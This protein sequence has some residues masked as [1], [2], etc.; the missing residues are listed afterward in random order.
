MLTEKQIAHYRTFG[1]V[2]HRELFS[3]KEMESIIK[4]FD[5]IM[6][7]DRNGTPFKG[8]DS[9]TVLWFIEQRSSLIDILEDDRIYIPVE[10]LLGEEFLWVLS[11][12]NLFVGDTKWH[13]GGGTPPVLDH[14]KVLFYLDSLTRNTG[15]LRVITGS[16]RSEYQLFLSKYQGKKAWGSGVEESL[17]VAGSE[18]PSYALETHPGDVVFASENLWLLLFMVNLEDVCLT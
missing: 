5:E 18:I 7:I 2:I 6:S 12:A 9:Q 13:G 1:F 15:S 11:D 10:Q 17:G 14:V 4:D 3:H 8:T 16:H